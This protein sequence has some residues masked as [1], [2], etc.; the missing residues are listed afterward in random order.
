M[1]GAD[2]APAQFAVGKY[3]NDFFQVQQALGEYNEAL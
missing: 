3:V 2:K 1:G